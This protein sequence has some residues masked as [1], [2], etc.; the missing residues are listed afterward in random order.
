M[1]TMLRGHV[2]VYAAWPHIFCL[3][4][5]KLCPTARWVIRSNVHLWKRLALIASIYPERRKSS[6]C[7]HNV[8]CVRFFVLGR[9]LETLVLAIPSSSMAYQ[10]H[11]VQAPS[12]GQDSDLHIKPKWHI[13]H[14]RALIHRT[15][16]LDLEILGYQE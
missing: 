5:A 3:N 12:L 8:V 4:V 11:F 10:E 6:L 16:L 1:V 7:W 2:K 14:G 13:S 9:V 15:K